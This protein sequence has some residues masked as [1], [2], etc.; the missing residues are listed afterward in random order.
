MEELQLEFTLNQLMNYIKDGNL[1]GTSAT[2]SIG[3]IEFDGCEYQI[4]VRLEKSKSEYIG[5]SEIFSAIS[6]DEFKY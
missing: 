2:A 4:Q 6:I 5:M 3:E 1:N